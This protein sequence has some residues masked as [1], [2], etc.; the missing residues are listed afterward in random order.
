MVKSFCIAVDKTLEKGVSKIVAEE[1]E[2]A[3]M[4]I[5][6]DNG[7]TVLSNDNSIKVATDTHLDVPTPT[8]SDDD[9]LQAVNRLYVDSPEADNNI[10]HKSGD[11][12]INGFKEVNASTYNG[13]AKPFNEAGYT[14][15]ASVPSTDFRFIFRGVTSNWM[16]FG[17]A[18]VTGSSFV[19]NGFSSG[20][21][22]SSN[23][24]LFMTQIDGKTHILT[25][26]RISAGGGF[27]LDMFGV[28]SGTERLTVTMYESREYEIAPPGN[29]ISVTFN[30]VI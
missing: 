6:N 5:K 10:V 13:D 25:K 3:G 24:N 16:G 7:K 12:V 20:D 14:V 17:F 8:A 1:A 23:V 18:T 2:I 15:V 27:I 11:E 26:R 22:S 28:T 21:I 29:L 19:I 4:S 30:S 9:D